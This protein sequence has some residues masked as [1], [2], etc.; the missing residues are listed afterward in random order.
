[1]DHIWINILDIKT[2]RKWLPDVKKSLV[3]IFANTITIQ[4]RK[5]LDKEYISNDVVKDIHYCMADSDETGRNIRC[6][7]DEMSAL[8]GYKLAFMDCERSYGLLPQEFKQCYAELVRYYQSYCFQE[9]RTLFNFLT[10]IENK[11]KTGCYDGNI[12]SKLVIDLGTHALAKDISLIVGNILKCPVQVQVIGHSPN[13][14]LLYLQSIYVLVCMFIASVIRRCAKLVLPSYRNTSKRASQINGTIFIQYENNMENLLP[15]GAT[16]DWLEYSGIN[17]DKVIFYFNREDSP[18]TLK[19]RK[20]LTERGFNWINYRFPHDHSDRLV[21]TFFVCFARLLTA[22]RSSGTANWRRGLVLAH[23]MNAIS[24]HRQALKKYQVQAVYQHNEFVPDQLSLSIAARLENAAFIWSWWS[25]IFM[26]AEY[27]HAIADLFFAWGELDLGITHAVSFDYRYAV[28]CG[29]LGYHGKQDDDEARAQSIRMKLSDKPRFILTIFDTSHNAT[30]DMHI[31]TTMMTDFYRLILGLVLEH[32]DWACLIK[33][34]GNSF[35]NLPLDTGIQE[36]MYRLEREGRALCLPS[37]VKPGLAAIA[38]DASVSYCVNTAGILG[39]L[40]SGKPSI[41]YDPSNITY[42]PLVTAGAEGIIIFRKP[43][44]IR[45]ALL[46]IAAGEGLYGDLSPWRALIDPFGDNLGRKR[47]G[48]VIRDY[49]AARNQG[50]GLD[51]ALKQAVTAHAERYGASMV[52]VRLGEHNRAGDR[53]WA[54]T[55]RRHYPDW[56]QPLPFTLACRQASLPKLTVD[57]CRH[58]TCQQF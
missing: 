8:V 50:L 43:D 30:G 16:L 12:I 55:L 57:E 21:R 3:K 5:L 40:S 41:H 42:H 10:Y 38:G 48:E 29:A 44:D 39:A 17:R 13:R 31:L 46:S 58:G 11:Y 45:R 51:D 4:A 22:L 1:L 37:T 47:S 6:R 27:H 49:M 36:Q 15:I 19:L 24:W 28:Q 9:G 32:E 7:A 56:P 14:L 25:V 23:A 54:E 20:D 33:S 52:S 18:A 2:L 53:L 34:K 26:D 35:R